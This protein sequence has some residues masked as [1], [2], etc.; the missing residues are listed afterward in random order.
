MLRLDLITLESE[1]LRRA[2]VGKLELVLRSVVDKAG[3][4]VDV[5]R[6][7]EA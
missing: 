5:T 3:I 2:D 7:G 6:N 1:Y 4:V